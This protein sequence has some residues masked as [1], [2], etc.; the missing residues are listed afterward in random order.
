MARVRQRQEFSRS[1]TRAKPTADGQY[2]SLFADYAFIDGTATSFQ[3]GRV[4]RMILEG[5]HGRKNYKKPEPLNSEKKDKL[6]VLVS[7][8]ELKDEDQCIFSAVQSNQTTRSFKEILCEVTLRVLASGDLQMEKE[9][10]KT[11]SSLVAQVR[12]RR[13]A[14]RRGRDPVQR[15][16][17][18]NEIRD[19]ENIDG[20]VRSV[21]QP[22]LNDTGNRRSARARTVIV[23]D[24]S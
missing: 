14:R 9:E 10:Y 19:F 5:A 3:I 1:E 24:I 23:R 2:V 4:D 13:E 20:T 15:I 6:M 18:Q 22:Q 8:Y 21:V 17:V 16:N 12:G 7:E 11:I